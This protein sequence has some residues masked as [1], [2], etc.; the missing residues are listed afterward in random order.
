MTAIYGT[1]EIM[2]TCGIRERGGTLGYKRERDGS[3]SAYR[4]LYYTSRKELS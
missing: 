2:T 4:A 3:C 1:K